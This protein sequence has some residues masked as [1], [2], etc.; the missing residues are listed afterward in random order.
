MRAPVIILVYNRLKHFQDCVFSLQ[1]CPEAQETDLIIHS[2]CAFRDEDI[3]AVESIRNFIE[4]LKG[5]NKVILL[6]PNENIGPYKSFDRLLKFATKNYRNFIF[7]EDDLV[8]STGFL[9]YH[10]NALIYYENDE[11]I[12]AISGFSH[13][14]LSKE[15]DK[16]TDI[17]KSKRFNP[18]GFSCWSTY[19]LEYENSNF[20][21]AK[22]K[23]DDYKS[24]LNLLGIDL[25]PQIK[26]MILLGI[27]MTNDYKLIMYLLWSGKFCL[28]PTNSF[29]TNF[30]LDGS[31]AHTSVSSASFRMYKVS[32]LTE[33]VPNFRSSKSILQIESHN[34]IH[35][36]S[37]RNKIKYYLSHT[38]FYGKLFRLRKNRE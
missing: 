33:N 30:G 15:T 4:K 3:L 21:F 29:V 16:R 25:Y 8:V 10:N 27:P 23:I 5:F 28:F 6:K 35:F 9:T 19:W 20:H 12:F 24:E 13:Y 31:G 22:Y 17:F 32:E 38:P 7:M 37:L 36:D 2:D 14:G 34:K 1:S 11:S 26:N 18:W